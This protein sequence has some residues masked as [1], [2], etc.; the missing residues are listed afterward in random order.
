MTIYTATVRWTRDPGRDFAKG[1]YSCAQSQQITHDNV[2]VMSGKFH[3]H[4]M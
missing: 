2:I 3:Y 1:Q 4:C